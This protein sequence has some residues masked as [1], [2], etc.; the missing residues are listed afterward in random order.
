V[1]ELVWEIYSKVSG[2]LL[3][4]LSSCKW[5]SRHPEDDL[6]HSI[7]LELLFWTHKSVKVIWLREL[8]CSVHLGD[9]SCYGDRVASEL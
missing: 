2:S 3:K 1:H 9:V 5:G 4:Y 6:R 7:I 8:N